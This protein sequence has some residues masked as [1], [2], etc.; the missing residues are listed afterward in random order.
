MGINTRRGFIK[1]GTAGITASAA[2][3][4]GLPLFTANR[5]KAE[6]S[7][8]FGYP[9]GG[10]DVETI[11]QLGYNGYKRIQIEGAV[12]K[13]CALGTFHAII[14]RLAEVVGYPYDTIPTPM[15]E[16]ASGG[17]AGF[18]TF[19]GALNG[20]WAAIGLICG[21]SDATGSISDLLSWYAEA[22]LPTNIIEILTNSGKIHR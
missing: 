2:A 13:E 19:C 3:G 5:A 7:H 11:R 21:K 12:H 9:M 6:A 4:V 22:I 18:S 1:I 14:G 17:V 10:L 15:M 8:P 20:A 16:C